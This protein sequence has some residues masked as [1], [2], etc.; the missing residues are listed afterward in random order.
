M[1]QAAEARGEFPQFGEDERNRRK[2]RI[3]DGGPLI[4]LD[5]YGSINTHESSYYD[6]SYYDEAFLGGTMHGTASTSPY[7]YKKRN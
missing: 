5:Q 1:G 4:D 3:L 2:D 7:G 6:E